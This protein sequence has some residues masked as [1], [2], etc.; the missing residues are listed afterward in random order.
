MPFRRLTST[1]ILGAV[2][3]VLAVASQNVHA[4]SPERKVTIPTGTTIEVRLFNSLG[5]ATSR[6]GERFDASLDA[7]IVVGDYVVV[8]KG[9]K[10]AGKVV[11]ARPSG[12]LK[13][14][15]ALVIRLTS[16]EVSGKTYAITTSRY[17]RRGQ[18]H[19]KRDAE[20]VGGGAAA[21]AAIGALAGGGKGA[22]IGAG[23]GA[24]GG[25]AAAYSTG[26]KD[27]VLPSETRLRFVLRE[28]LTVTKAR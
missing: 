1:T 3:L 7:P 13:T 8:H 15:A 18:S 27:I 11:E 5:S 2:A 25:T 23:A 20:M 12:H 21:G 6:S 17:A 22:A 19:K 9:A 26:K 14:P 10:V 4:G 16:L 24:G 28:P